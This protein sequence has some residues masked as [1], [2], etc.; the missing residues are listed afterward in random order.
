MTGTRHGPLDTTQ[1]LTVYIYANYFEYQR[2]GYG[3]AVATLFAGAIM[4]ITLVQWRVFGR[5]VHYR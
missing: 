1:N 4:T 2:M 5:R 3:A